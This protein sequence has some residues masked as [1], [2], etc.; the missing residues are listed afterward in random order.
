MTGHSMSQHPHDLAVLQNWVQAV[1]THPDGV[2]A[3]IESTQAQQQIAVSSANVEHVIER[4]RSQTSQQRLHIYANAYFARLL[5]CLRVEFPALLHA[6]GEE[7]FDAFAFGYLQEYPSKSYTLAQLAVNFPQFLRETRPPTDDSNLP[8]WPDFLIDLATLERTY[9]EAFDA[10]G[11]EDERM[12][13]AADLQDIAPDRWPDVRLIP[14]ECFRVL[15]LH[16]PVH[17][18][19]TAVR[20]G[21]TEIP[22]PAPATTYLAVTRRQYVV[23]R[24]PVTQAQYELLSALRSGATLGEAILRAV[25]VTETEVES[26]AAEL[27]IWFREWTAAGYFRRVELQ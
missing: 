24:H 26:L 18:Y 21:K 2:A 12:L 10:A 15:T 23:R 14:V 13:Q 19:A 8:D 17:E 1:I 3:G 20:N 4:S 5:E 11:G 6:L 7:T 27:Q 25:E 22:V 16:F 9:A